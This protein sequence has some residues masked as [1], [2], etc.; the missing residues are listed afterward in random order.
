VATQPFLRI[1]REFEKH[2]ELSRVLITDEGDDSRV[3]PWSRLDRTDDVVRL[4]A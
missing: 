1:R 3:V 4:P 2:G